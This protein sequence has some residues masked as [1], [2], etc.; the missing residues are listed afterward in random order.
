MIDRRRFLHSLGLTAL[1]PFAVGCKAPAEAKAKEMVHL[2]TTFVAGFQYYDGMKEEVAE[3]LREGAELVLR[4]EPGNPHD[5]NAI[6]VL[7]LEG[8]KL[9]YLPRADN[10]VLAAMADQA[11]QLRAELTAVDIRTEPWNRA[12][13]SVY[14]TI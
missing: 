5:E 8:F 12:L 9:G 3:T 14:Q 1:L 6:E 4:R 2:L 10:T 7:T 13:V 11:I